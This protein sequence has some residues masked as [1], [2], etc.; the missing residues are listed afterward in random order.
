MNEQAAKRTRELFLSGL[1]CAE[2]VLIS[3]AESRHIQSDFIPRIATGFCSGMARTGGQCGAVSG[4]IMAINL[5]KGRQS[6]TESVDGSYVLVRELMKQFAEQFGSTN[7]RMLLG[8]DLDTPEGQ[9]TFRANQL[10][11]RCYDYAEGATRMAMSLLEE[12]GSKDMR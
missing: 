11:E 1:Y 2:S 9:Q 10:I 8:C 4:A 7:C 6:P 5:F 3:I 12:Q